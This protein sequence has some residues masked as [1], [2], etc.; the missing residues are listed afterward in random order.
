MNRVRVLKGRADMAGDVGVCKTLGGY[1]ACT[2]RFDG[3]WSR[4]L[5]YREA[6]QCAAR[7]ARPEAPRR[8]EI[9]TAGK[10]IVVT[11]FPNGTVTEKD[12]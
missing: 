10:T 3:W 4:V 1:I 12:M 2:S 11:S 6:I 5:S 7:L 9:T 8:M